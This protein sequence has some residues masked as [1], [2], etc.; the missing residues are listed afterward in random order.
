MEVSDVIVS[1]LSE[2]NSFGFYFLQKGS[3]KP[4][5]PLNLKNKNKTK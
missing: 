3:P 5:N 2:K 1:V 4:Q